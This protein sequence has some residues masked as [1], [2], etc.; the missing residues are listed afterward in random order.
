MVVAI[1]GQ[2]F[3]AFGAKR[4]HFF[5][6][7]LCFPTLVTSGCSGIFATIQWRGRLQKPLFLQL[8]K[9]S[10]KFPTILLSMLLSIPVSSPSSRMTNQSCQIPIVNVSASGQTLSK[11]LN[12]LITSCLGRRPV[13]V[14]LSRLTSRSIWSARLALQG[15]ATCTWWKM[16]HCRKE[17]DTTHSAPATTAGMALCIVECKDETKLRTRS[18]Y[19]AWSKMNIQRSF[20]MFHRL[21]FHPLCVVLIAKWGGSEKNPMCATS[22]RRFS[23]NSQHVINPAFPP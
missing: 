22:E 9:L 1:L 11:Q 23:L 4:F 10:Q 7:Q 8:R 20:R 12:V 14:L 2:D 18:T 19:F 13:T 6:T 17:M 15:P 21:L 3:T 5:P 16:E